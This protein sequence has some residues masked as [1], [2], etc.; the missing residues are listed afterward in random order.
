MPKTTVVQELA[1]E[2]KV[3]EVMTRDVIT[4]TPQTSM[5]ELGEV[6]RERRI[7]GAPVTENG[8]LV[9]IISVENL[10][11]ALIGG[12]VNAT[13]GEKMTPNPVTL[14]AGEA[15]VVALACFAKY[16]FDSFP[17][18]DEKGRLI[19][20]IT[21]GDVLEGL[22]EKLEE[23]VEHD[24]E[25]RSRYWISP[26]FEDFVSDRTNFI[27]R[28]DVVAHDFDHAGEA[29]SKVKRALTRLGLSPQIIRQ[30]AI[31]VYEAEMNIIIHTDEG[32]EIVAEIQPEQII[33]RAA[34]TGPGIPDIEQAMQPGFSTAPKWIQELGFGAGMGLTNI[35]RCTD[36]MRLE[37]PRGR[38]TSLEVVIY[39]GRRGGEE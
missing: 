30:A 13:V 29:S 39:L 38:W 34:D 10:I 24:E 23:E 17:V 1:Y 16:D 3:E 22:L 31:A 7:S 4:V 19:G 18:V 8:E 6:L 37:S 14:H 5:A 20:I 9:G 2:I 28:Y 36:E 35:Q 21:Q 15:V 33:I 32:G 11:K 27:L 26:F 25:E 12:E